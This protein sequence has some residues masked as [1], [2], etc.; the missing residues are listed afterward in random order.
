LAGLYRLQIPAET[1]DSLIFQ[2]IQAGTVAYPASYSVVS[3]ASFLGCK[4]ARTWHWPLTSTLF[5]G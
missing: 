5:W 1:R 4:G 2:N 3:R